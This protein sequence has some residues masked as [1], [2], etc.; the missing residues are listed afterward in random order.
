VKAKTISRSAGFVILRRNE[1]VQIEKLINQH[2][3]WIKKPIN[4]F[5]RESVKQT[6]K[7][8]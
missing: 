3:I 2:L 7:T 4:L 8:A 5:V 6:I 1:M